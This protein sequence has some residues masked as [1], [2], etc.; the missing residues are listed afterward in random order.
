MGDGTFRDVTDEAG[1]GGSGWTTSC[2]IVDLNGDG[3]PEIF[4]AHYAPIQEV[5]TKSCEKQGHPMSCTPTM[6]TGV[7]HNL[8]LNL[9][10][11]RFRDVTNECGIQRPDGKG[12]GIVAADFDGSGRINLFVTN[13]TTPNFYFVNQTEGPGKPL[14]FAER[15]LESG[16]A[17]NEEGRAQASMGIA[18]GDVNGDGL[19]DLFV[20]TFYDDYKSLYLQSPDHIFSIESRRANLF[21]PM[22]HMLGFGA[23][24]LDGELDGWPDLIVSNGH[25]ERSYAPTV[26]DLMPPQ[27]FKNLGGGKFVELS[28]R[29]LGPYF[30]KQYLGR[31]IALL[32][33]DRD[34][35]EDACISHL[36]APAALLTNRTQETGHYL[37]VILHG[38]VSSRDAIGSILRLT[39][40]GH[41]WTR[42]VIGGNGYMATNERKVIFGL[43]PAQRID[44]LEIRWSSGLKQT[45]ESPQ[46]DQE[47]VIV[48]GAPTPFVLPR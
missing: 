12:L 46:A 38:T 32:D 20:T 43:G 14:K 48:E 13:D 27:Y 39:A 21:D 6:F 5:L 10:D 40:G 41:T 31:T 42:Q 17:L 37:A 23:Q 26:P 1:V 44:R 30:Q 29:S 16:L 47:L 9:G 19:L 25:V 33:W 28:S 35:K 8:Y 4:V 7:Q 45:F 18:A 34:G 11:G 36:D 3:F 24:F 2:A 22:Y 15:G